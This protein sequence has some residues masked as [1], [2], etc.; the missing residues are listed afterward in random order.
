[1]EGFYLRK[2]KRSFVSCLLVW[3]L[4]LAGYGTSTSTGEEEQVE[5]TCL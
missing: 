4:I 5:G 3:G 2:M 1:M